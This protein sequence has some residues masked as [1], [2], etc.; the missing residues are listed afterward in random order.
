MT[1]APQLLQRLRSRGLEVVADGCDLVVR[2]RPAPSAAEVEELRA[3]KAEL[4]DA[5]QAEAV[6]ALVLDLAP[7]RTPEPGELV[8]L[9]FDPETRAELVRLEARYQT[10]ALPVRS[11][12][13]AGLSEREAWALRHAAAG[14]AGAQV[15]AVTVQGRAAEVRQAWP[16]GPQ[17]R[18]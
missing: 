5:L 11:V 13:Q 12:S 10:F 8:W 3:R 1:P 18:Q 2:G 14:M 4:L 17:T 9:C 7:G 16:I 6:Q 15:V